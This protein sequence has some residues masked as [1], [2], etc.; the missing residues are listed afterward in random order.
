MRGRASLERGL[1]LSEVILGYH[2]D[3]VVHALLDMRAAGQ[4]VAAIART[5]PIHPTVLELASPLPQQMKPPA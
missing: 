1:K 5:M 2:G 3:E 4:P